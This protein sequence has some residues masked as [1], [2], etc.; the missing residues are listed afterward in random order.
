MPCAIQSAVVSFPALPWSLCL[1]IPFRLLFLSLHRMPSAPHRVCHVRLVCCRESDSWS[2][3]RPPP[4]I[5]HHVMWCLV[6][7]LLRFVLAAVLV[8]PFAL[9]CLVLFW[10]L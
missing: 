3:T 2:D 4:R 9:Q 1:S 6:P 5:L 10:C 7:S 8:S